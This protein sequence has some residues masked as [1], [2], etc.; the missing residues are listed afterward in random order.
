MC[1]CFCVCGISR[2]TLVPFIINWSRL[3]KTLSAW[4]CE[5]SHVHT[6]ES[7]SFKIITSSLQ[8]LLFESPMTDILTR[9]WYFWLIRLEVFFYLWLDVII[10][11]HLKS[12]HNQNYLTDVINTLDS[13]HICHHQNH[14]ITCTTHKT[15]HSTKVMLVTWFKQANLWFFLILIQIILS[16]DLNHHFCIWLES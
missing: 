10:S 12:R 2:L 3:G 4:S 15:I 13:C 11:N 7:K 5:V 14:I 6:F 16:L 9:T 1:V 8:V